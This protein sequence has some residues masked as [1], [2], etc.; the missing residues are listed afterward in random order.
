MGYS[1]SQVG[2]YVA[3]NPATLEKWYKKH[4]PNYLDDFVEMKPQIGS[5]QKAS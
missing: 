2:E 5:Y 1:L 3:T 4:S